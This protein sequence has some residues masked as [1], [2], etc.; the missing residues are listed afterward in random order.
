MF[1]QSR[2]RVLL[3]GDFNARTGGLNEWDILDPH[4][5]RH[6]DVSGI[7]ERKSRDHTLNNTGRRLLTVCESTGVCLLN[8]RSN[9]DKNGLIT[10]QSLNGRGKSVIDYAV[11]SKDMLMGCHEH[12]LDFRV[13]PIHTCPTRAAG[14]KYDHC[15]IVT[16]VGW[17]MLSCLTP[18]ESS[19][20]SG[21]Y[22]R[23]R[24]EYRALYTDI[25]QTDGVVLGYLTKI[26]LDST[27]VEESCENLTKAIL[28]AAEVLHSKVWGGVL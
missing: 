20:D 28:R 27:T 4:I 13:I 25:M 8:G 7:S 26:R 22:I 19:E 5:R 10:F 2:G 12:M 1:F 15:P 16:A 23:W 6:Y 17:N 18:K 9:T 3:M 14:G 21:P 11:V 24:P